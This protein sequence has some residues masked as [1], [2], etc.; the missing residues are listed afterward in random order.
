MSDGQSLFL[1]LGLLYLLECFHWLRRGTVAF[2]SAGS[3]RWRLR[4]DDSRPAGTAR[5]FLLFCN[6]L[7]PLGLLLFTH[8]W[9]VAFSPDGIA[10]APANLAACASTR[11]PFLRFDDIRTVCADG[12]ELIVNGAVFANCASGPQAQTLA[13]LVKTMVAQPVEKRQPALL[14]DLETLYNCRTAGERVAACRRHVRWLRRL[15]NL[16]FLFTFGL[17]PLATRAYGL[18][19]IIIPAAAGMLLLAWTIALL[20]LRAH[21]ALLPEARGER[22]LHLVKMLLCP[23]LAMRAHDALLANVFS[24][25]PP[26]VVAIHLLRANALAAFLARH[27]RSL[28]FPLQPDEPMPT[29]VTAAWAWQG[30]FQ[31]QETMKLLK[32]NG[33]DPEALLAV[34]RASDPTAKAY[35]PRCLAQFTDGAL[36]E[37]PDC[38]GVKT[39]PFAPQPHSAAPHQPQEPL[40]KT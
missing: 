12:L 30:E 16:L 1:V 24:A 8:R 31:L 37:C 20:F 11:T 35:C 34:P 36:A 2:T 23:P 25:L 27:L 10:L 6:P 3:R 9:P 17:T 28:L 5:G 33:V 39:A 15:G 18:A 7:P 14:A 22:A 13:A 29:E 32:A 21:R 4:D 26:A 38:R 40:C 19:W